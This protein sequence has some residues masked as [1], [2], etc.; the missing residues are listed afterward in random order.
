MTA[1]I[2][3][4]STTTVTAGPTGAARSNDGFLDIKV[5]QPH[6]IGRAHV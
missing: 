3:A 2:I 5:P 6:Q 4:S 1:K